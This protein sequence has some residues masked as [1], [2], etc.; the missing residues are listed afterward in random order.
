MTHLLF[1]YDWLLIDAAKA[2]ES[3]ISKLT[4][5]FMNIIH[6]FKFYKF[7]YDFYVD[8]IDIGRVQ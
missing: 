5:L 7:S 1:I 6:Q 8:Y 4:N 2:E 3:T